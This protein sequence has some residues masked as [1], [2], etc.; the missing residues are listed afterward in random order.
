MKTKKKDTKPAQKDERTKTLEAA[1]KQLQTSLIQTS[2]RVAL[3]LLT[4][5]LL[6]I[7]LDSQ[8]DTKPLLSLIGI[9]LGVLITFISVRRYVEAEYPGTFGGDKE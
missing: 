5:S 7:W 2:W 6:G 9:G 4:F 3:S 8:F 1:Q